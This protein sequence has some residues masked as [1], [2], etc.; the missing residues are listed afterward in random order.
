MIVLSKRNGKQK[1]YFVLDQEPNDSIVFEA[2]HANNPQ[3]YSRFT[4]LHSTGNFE[5]YFSPG[6]YNTA[7]GT[8]EFMCYHLIS[9]TFEGLNIS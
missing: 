7:V 3:K 5:G 4:L 8:L 6:I 9:L 1:H 2:C